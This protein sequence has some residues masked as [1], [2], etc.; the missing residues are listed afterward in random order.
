MCCRPYRE[1][2][3][4]PG[5]VPWASSMPPEKQLFWVC[6]QLQKKPL[7]FTTGANKKESNIKNSQIVRCDDTP[8][9]DAW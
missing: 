7:S 9:E 6:L 4:L 5:V 2:P 1:Q 3:Q 8:D